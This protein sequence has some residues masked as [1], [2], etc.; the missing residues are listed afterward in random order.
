M[1]VRF[2]LDEHL[3][4]PLWSAVRHH[5]ATGGPFLDDVVRAGDPPD[6]PLGAADIASAAETA[7]YRRRVAEAERLRKSL[8]P[9]VYTRRDSTP[10]RYTVPVS[11]AVRVELTSAP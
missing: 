6:L 1:N 3:R 8:V 5:N 9:A 4:G 2:V 7:E 10:L 11:G